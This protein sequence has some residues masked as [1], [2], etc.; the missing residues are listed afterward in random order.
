M[1]SMRRATSLR[2]TRDVSRSEIAYVISQ[3]YA[4]EMTAQIV[5]SNAVASRAGMGASRFRQ[6]HFRV[7][8]RGIFSTPQEPVTWRLR[9][10]SW[11][12]VHAANRLGG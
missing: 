7:G 1:R 2:L 11:R 5:L 10:N 6:K 4:R 9:P 3:R 12:S 8:A